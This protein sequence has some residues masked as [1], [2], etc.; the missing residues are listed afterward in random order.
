MMPPADDES[1]ESL[2][3]AEAPFGVEASEDAMTEGAR[4]ALRQAHRLLG[5]GATTR[6]ERATVAQRLI[7]VVPALAHLAYRL[8]AEYERNM[9]GLAAAGGFGE[10]TTRLRRAITAHVREIIEPEEN[11]RASEENTLRRA[12]A[13]AR[14]INDPAE[15]LRKL[16]GAC[17]PPGLT[18]PNHYEISPRGVM[19]VDVDAEGNTTAREVCSRPI[20]ITGRI[21]DPM[22]I[23]PRLVVIR[24]HDGRRWLGR[25]VRQGQ[26]CQA[27]ELASLSDYGLPAGSGTAMDIATYLNAFLTANPD[28]PEARAVSSMG[29]RDLDTPTPSFILG[30]E[31][32]RA[33]GAV[34]A[35]LDDTDPTT[36]P[37][38]ALHLRTDDAAILSLAKAW[39]TG[40]TWEGWLGVVNTAKKHP[41]L[42]VALRAAIAPIL[43]QVLGAPN[44]VLDIAGVTSQGKSTALYF[45]ASAMGFPDDKRQGIVRPWNATRVGIERVSA[46]CA[47]LPLFLDDTRQL[48][49]KQVEDVASVVY[50]VVNGQA[51]GRG[52]AT[53]SVQASASWQTVMLSTGETPITELAAA[54]GASARTLTLFGSPLGGTDQEVDAREIRDGAFTH[55]GWAARRVI[56]WLLKPDSRKALVDWYKTEVREID[57][58]TAPTTAGR[59]V[60][61]RATDYAAALRVAGKVLR[62]VGVPA[63]DDAAAVDALVQ[64]AMAETVAGADQATTALHAVYGWCCERPEAFYGRHLRDKNDVALPPSGGKWIGSWDGADQWTRININ[65]ETLRGFLR[66]RRFDVEA[67]LRTW[68]AREV[69]IGQDAVEDGKKVK[70]T[71]RVVKINSIPVRC[72]VLDRAGMTRA[73]IVLSED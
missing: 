64:R 59:A 26:V 19:W 38:N 35:Q 56:E 42:A 53:G 9:A 40:G 5:A 37:K 68:T 13:M 24:W 58:E 60:Q 20:L 6:E 47:D 28:I 52:T 70:R 61:S 22:N 71:T 34:P 45:A 72:V 21:V 67:T 30:T 4:E 8:P 54:G 66:E 32:L 50:M 39:R 51:R 17:I 31:V 16:P 2:L 49:K 41:A 48:N 65:A 69:V 46:F 10:A 3:D 14:V 33:S 25:C 62:A 73:G 29:W 36:W 15:A 11:A 23:Q 1:S 27:R 57:K 55:Y 43:L 7:A 44:F 12:E 18:M 63:W